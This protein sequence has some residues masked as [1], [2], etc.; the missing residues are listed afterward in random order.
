MA[1]ARER[2]ARALLVQEPRL[3]R[4]ALDGPDECELYREAMTAV[5]A[6]QGL[7]LVDPLAQWGPA[8]APELFVDVVHLDDRGYA[9]LAEMLAGTIVDQGLLASGAR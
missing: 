3:R 6:E 5:A 2:G 8:R 1:L 7:P 9:A 4:L